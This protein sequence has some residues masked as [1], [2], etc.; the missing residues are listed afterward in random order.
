MFNHIQVS[1]LHY[2]IYLTWV[3]CYKKVL[4][5][6]RYKSQLKQCEIYYIYNIYTLCIYIYTYIHMLRWL[7]VKTCL[8]FLGLICHNRAS[9]SQMLLASGPIPVLF[10]HIIA[11]CKQGF[12]LWPTPAASAWCWLVGGLGFS[13]SGTC[14]TVQILSWTLKT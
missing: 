1:K 14:E 11:H 8:N 13:E 2:A 6:V 5:C 10:W 12:E 4:W 7:E 3:I 9:V